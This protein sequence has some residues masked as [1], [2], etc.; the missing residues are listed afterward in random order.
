LK[1]FEAIKALLPQSRAFELFI[2]NNK[3]KLIEALSVLPEDIRTETEK[4]YLDLFPDTTRSPE[5]WENL[6]AVYFISDELPKRRNILTSLWRMRSGG[7]SAPFL[8]EVL[9]TLGNIKVIENVPVQDPRL[10][11][12]VDIAVCDTAIMV[13]DNPQAVCD[14]KLGDEGFIP[15]V[16]RNDTSEL[17]SLPDEPSYWEM[18][19]F[20]CKSVYKDNEN[21][22]IFIESLKMNSVWR[23]YVEYLIL[24]MKPVQST[25][26]V[27]INWT[28]GEPNND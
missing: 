20:V 11:H 9:E 1:F 7:Q 2:N 24:K 12:I 26:I 8:Q 23:N 22:I 6:F 21:K 19:F 13:C 14:C 28:E 25:A 17:Y 27:F 3:R 16:L 4:A 18:C 5:K 10:D 15:T